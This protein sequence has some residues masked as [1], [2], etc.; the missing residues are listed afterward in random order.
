MPHFSELQLSRKTRT[1]LWSICEKL[2][3][4][5]RRSRFDCITEILAF[6]PQPIKPE[7][8]KDKDIAVINYDG[9]S[10]EG[11]TRPYT[12]TVNG[13]LINR[14]GT[15]AQAERFCQFQGYQVRDAQSQ[16][17]E[18]L[19][20]YIEFQEI[21]AEEL[22]KDDYLFHDDPVATQTASSMMA[23]EIP[24]GYFDLAEHLCDVLFA[25]EGLNH[26]DMPKDVKYPQEWAKTLRDANEL[27][28]QIFGELCHRGRQVSQK[29]FLNNCLSM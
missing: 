6:Q 17:Q 26:V 18:E 28:M 1:Q 7:Q 3:I 23:S 29:E 16:A 15:Y 20:E 25:F 24:N 2:S 5:K 11:L 4:P 14:T 27:V 22:S 10:F 8:A 21:S 12:I 9:D 19:A 13:L